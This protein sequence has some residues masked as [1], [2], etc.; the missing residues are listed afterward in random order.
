LSAGRFAGKPKRFDAA[1]LKFLHE[2]FVMAKDLA[3]RRAA[4]RALHQEGWFVLPNPWDVGSA[5]RLERMGFKALASTSSG[6]A[7]S[8]G[9][10]DGEMSRDE[11]LAHLRVLCGATELPVNADFEAGFADSPEGVMENVAL[12]VKTGVAGLSIEDRIGKDL[13]DLPLAVERIRAA[14]EAID[15]SGEDVLLVGRSE[16]YLIGRTGVDATIERLVAYAEAGADCLYAPGMKKL[17][18]IAAVVKAVSPKPVN[19]LL[20]AGMR[21]AELAGV[22]VRRVS[23]GGGLAAAAWGGFE[24]AAQMLIED[25]TIPARGTGVLGLGGRAK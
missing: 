10:E 23:V 17:E 22:G 4:F 25:G 20:L 6:L 21:V 18:E 2:E 9:R 8:M 11:V 3:A 12:A 5:V 13:Y 14:R 24:R 19:A 1:A 16:G 7:W 15:R